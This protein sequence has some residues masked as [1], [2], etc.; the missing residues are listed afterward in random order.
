[1]DSTRPPTQ[2]TY[3]P[4]IDGLRAI[5][6]LSVVI[7]HLSETLLPGGFIGV[8]IFFVISGFLISNHILTDVAASRFSFK[9]FYL[10][11]ARRILPALYG[12]ILFT[13]LLCLLTLVPE[14]IKSS[15]RSA[16]AALF[17]KANY[18][19][20][21][22]VDYFAPLSTKFPFLHLWSL[23]VEEQFYFIFPV[24]VVL[25]AKPQCLQKNYRK[26]LLGFLFFIF[27]VSLFSAEYGLGQKAFKK[28]TF[29]SITS[30]AC[31]LLI[32]VLL[33]FSNFKIQKKIGAE[34]LAFTG[35]FGLILCLFLIDGKTRFP[36]LIALIPCLCTAFII[37]AHS[38]RQTI[39]GA[40]LTL[41]PMVFIGLISYSLYLYHWP[42]IALFKYTTDDPFSEFLQATFIFFTSLVLAFLSWRYVEQRFR[43]PMKVSKNK[44]LVKIFL[45]P[46]L[47][48]F[49]WLH[50]TIH[51]QG[52]L[53]YID[54]EKMNKTLRYLDFNK[55]CHNRFDERTCIFGDVSQKPEVLLLGDS[56]AGHYQPF[57]EEVGKVQKFSLIARS[58]DGC[59]PLITADSKVIDQ[60]TPE[61]SCI[62][63]IN[64]AYKNANR[65]QTIIFA[66]AWTRYLNSELFDKDA[67]SGYQQELPRM[68]SQLRAQNKKVLFFE[69]IPLCSGLE[70]FY[71]VRFSVKSSMM[72]EA[73]ER[74]KVLN[75]CG[76]ASDEANLH[77][78]TIVEKSGAVF[79]PVLADFQSQ[80][81]KMP[82]YNDEYFYKDGGH[83]NQIGSQYLG[84]WSGAHSQMLKNLARRNSD[85]PMKKKTKE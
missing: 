28:W 44:E 13:S 40:F 71:G 48:V 35:F 45:I 53:P 14:E 77:F 31:E 79:V 34:L 56:H 66:G 55:Y 52:D 57:L 32:G 36:G 59:F 50:F 51:I 3:R 4:E 6:V 67:I 2:T 46:T 1:M 75:T 64:W 17:Y 33:A 25:F 21:K 68:I 70:H 83:L 22:D 73:E 78:K 7:F 27:F 81:S 12:V 43:K 38:Q 58:N 23:S 42:L 69:Q 74:Q 60:L 30:R 65:F 10:K 49:G 20:A 76:R 29:F 85:P 61:P 41:R 47:V 72:N 15:S 16:L 24:I 63:Q 54:Y 18:H 19:F 39:V 11:R 8:D 26:Y 80:V 84:Q 9:E 37:A 5:A 62:D 82:F